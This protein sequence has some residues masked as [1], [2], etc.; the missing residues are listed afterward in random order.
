[1]TKVAVVGS[2]NMDLV[3]LVPRF[4]A[5]GETLIGSR[6]ETFP[7]GKG[8]NQAVA[9]ARLGA[10]V[11]MVGC[12]GGDGFGRE[13]LSGLAAEGV[14]TSAIHVSGEASTGVASILV[15]GGE[16]TI[17][18]VPGANHCLTPSMV[19]ASEQL[20]ASADVVLTQLEIP[21]ETVEAT[22]RLA[23]RH[24]VPLILN[25]AP[26]VRLSRALLD[27]VAC[28]T[29]NEHELATVLGAPS[30]P[31][32]D[33]LALLPG[34]VVM[35]K[36]EHG[37]YHVDGS[38]QFWHQPGFAVSAVDTTGAGDTFNAAL[39]AAWQG[40]LRQAMRF[41]AAAAALSVTRLG[42]QGG[43]PSAAAVESF[44][45]NSTQNAPS[46]T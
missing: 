41:A 45:Q 42:A 11:A 28:L 1:M 24:R 4:P 36:G 13:L 7:G 27:Q 26:A 16:N 32:P 37:A 39:A 38:G 31:F 20:I 23:S 2:I 40:G 6:F 12:V 15:S 18:V 34:K 44:L 30:L 14:D 43:M 46:L 35:T 25:P 5:P 9:A 19:E 33:M 21:L 10:E 3:A 8:A 22:A 17:V 29:P